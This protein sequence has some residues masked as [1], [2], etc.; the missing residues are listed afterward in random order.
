MKWRAIYFCLVI[1]LLFGAVKASGQA[2]AQV[3]EMETLDSNG[4]LA[5]QI[6]CN[7]YGSWDDGSGQDYAGVSIGDSKYHGCQLKDPNGQ[8]NYED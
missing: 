3:S 4:W 6:T 2:E 5:I 7:A 1:C 8:S